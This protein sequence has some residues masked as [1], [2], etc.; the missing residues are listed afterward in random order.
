LV[1]IADLIIRSWDIKAFY[2]SKGTLPLQVLFDQLWHPSH[3]SIFNIADNEYFI[4]VLFLANFICAICL[5]IGYKTRIST[6]LIW[7]FLASI[8]NRNPLI[9]QA[10][11]NL[12]RMMVFWG[13]FLPWGYLYSLDSFHNS[14]KKVNYNYESFASIAYVCQIVF[15][16]FFSALLKNSP[17]WHTEFTAVYYALSLDQLVTPIGKL[18]YPFPEALKM[19]T[20]S[21]YYVELVLPFLLLM[22]FFNSWLRIAIILSITGLQTGIYLTM[23]VGLFSVT[24]VV[25][26]LGLIPTSTFEWMEKIY[27]RK[28]GSLKNKINLL[29]LQYSSLN[30]SK[31]RLHPFP[32]AISEVLVAISLLLV[33][34]FNLH[35]VGRK[36]LPD[37]TFWIGELLKLN[38]HWGMFAPSVYKNDGWFIFEAKTTQDKKIDLV[39]NG[40]PV[41]YNKPKWVI[42][43]VKSDR[44]RKYGENILMVEKSQFR[45][46]LCQ[47][48][49]NDWNEK[50]PNTPIIQ[51]EIIYMHE[52]TL[53]NYLT[54]PIEKWSLCS[55]NT[56]S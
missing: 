5:L 47:Y 2:T 53:P 18:I 50:R 34:D 48:L 51:L 6:V 16:Y 23:N 54:D 33:L 31:I 46:Y 3:F 10:G 11:D 22:P 49:L 27:A 56:S 24:S 19:M 52:K 42:D 41:N 40:Q 26:M 7:I 37:N 17:E 20:A 39:R 45:P 9:T 30:Q 32:H 21:V 1:I 15:L 55:C 44:W 12:I 14:N 38:Q 4:H 28:L 25:I 35:S 8:H 29:R 43:V 36:I 13:M